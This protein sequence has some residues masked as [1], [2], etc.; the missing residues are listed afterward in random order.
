MPIAVLTLY[1]QFNGNRSLKEK[2]GQLQPLLSRIRKKF[3]LSVAEMD[4]Q[5]R[6]NETVIACAAVGN[7]RV[8]VQKELQSVI[9]FLATQFPELEI[10]QDSVEII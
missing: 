6:W 10:L 5:D 4:L 3:N 7:S 2:R 1:I 9:P 8:H